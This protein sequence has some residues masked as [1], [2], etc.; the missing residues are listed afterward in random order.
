MQATSASPPVRARA[1]MPLAIP[2]AIA[3]GW[4]LALVAQAT[5]KAELLHHDALLLGGP[6][7]WVALPVFLLAWQVMVAAMMLP[8][9]PR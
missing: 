6:P 5:G 3:A 9:P 7:L 2:A 8:S 4:A 1:R